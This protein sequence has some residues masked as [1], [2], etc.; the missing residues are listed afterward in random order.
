MQE[1]TR[2]TSIGVTPLAGPRAAD[3]PATEL[4]RWRSHPVR[5]SGKRLGA[6]LLVL[7][8]LPAGLW[9]LYGPFYGL[10]GVLILSGALSPYFLPTD[11]ALYAGGGESRFIGVTRRFTWSQYRTFYPDS[12]GVLLSPFAKPSRLE[13]FR[14]IYLRFDG[15]REQILNIVS[16][17]LRESGGQTLTSGTATRV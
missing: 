2:D 4:M 14:G 1:S 3:D 6:V 16:E 5:Q 9:A 11:Y 17:C 7:I 10:L 12:H 8:G 13:N 15:R